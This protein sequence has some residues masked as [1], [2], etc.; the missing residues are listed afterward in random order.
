M[1][2][3]NSNDNRT[4]I[5]REKIRIIIKLSARKFKQKESKGMTK[6]QTIT[7]IVEGIEKVLKDG[8]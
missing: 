6:A 3:K 5:D 4:I 2:N 1:N 8:N 7:E